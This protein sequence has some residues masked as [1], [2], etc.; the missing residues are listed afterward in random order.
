MIELIPAIDLIGGKCVRLSKGDFESKKEYDEDPAE[1]A[2]RFADCGIRRIH[3]VDL[4]GA[5]Q[6]APAN[7]SVLERI[8]SRVDVE[9]EWGGGIAT[10]A[11]LVTVFDAG[12]TQAVVGTVA[13]LKPDLFLE[14]LDRFGP[15]RIVLGADIR[16]GR[17]A[18]RGWLSEVPLR[19]EDL[20]DPFG[21]AGLSQVVC[22]DISRDGM[23]QGPATR[24]YV[25]LQKNYPDI[26]FSVSGGIASMD[27]VRAL[28]ALGLRRVI[29]GKALYEGKITLDEVKKWS[30]SA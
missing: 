17:I 1:V 2:A 24:L 7:L 5:K 22:T 9:L 11:D 6:A 8:R 20:L 26:T 13:A 14:W 4:E 12:A 15:D 23:L 30:Q 16:N 18:V 3:L 29:V 27:D 19:I 21:P 25:D 10:L 28:D